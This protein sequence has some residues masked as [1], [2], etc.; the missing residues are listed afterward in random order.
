MPAK[1]TGKL[2]SGLRRGVSTAGRFWSAPPPVSAAS[3][4]LAGTVWCVTGSFLGFNP[5]SLAEEE[6]VKRSGKVVSAVSGKTTHLLAGTGAGS[7]LDKALALGV[8]IVTE[9]EFVALLG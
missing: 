3:A 8:K 4:A 1:E 6:I 7:K 5:R 2:C 9:E